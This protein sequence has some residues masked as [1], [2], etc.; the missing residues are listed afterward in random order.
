MHTDLHDF[1]GPVAGETG[2]RILD[3]LPA[4]ARRSLHAVELPAGTEL[5]SQGRRIT[6]AFFPTTA[7]CSMVVELASGAKAETATVGSDGFVGVMVVLGHP[8]SY[9]SGVIEVSGQGYRVGARQLLE[10]CREHDAFRRALFGYSAYKLHLAS[11]SVACNS[12]HS[13]RQRLARWLLFAH[14]R[15]GR[16]DFRLTHEALS[17][18]LATTRPRVSL[19]AAKLRR[20]GLID[21][22]RGQVRILDRKRLESA[23]CECYADT[24]R[25]P[26]FQ[27][28]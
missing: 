8:I 7:V 15:V 10:L 25:A 16:N 17:A 5:V 21:Y 12:F 24:R 14:D 27:G 18:M 20:E 19:A 28:H 23:A 26:A 3:A 2:N 11:R 22:R 6:H 4:A 9:S 13:V 1:G